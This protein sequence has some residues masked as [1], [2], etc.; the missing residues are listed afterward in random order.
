MSRHYDFASKML[1]TQEELHAR[2]R[3]TAERIAADYKDKNLT[4][5][6]NPLVLVCVLKGSFIFTADLARALCDAGVPV[7]VE[8][9][10]VAS[11][12]ADVMSS[13]QVRLLL[14]TR[15]SVEQRHVLLVEDIVD[16]AL[17]LQYLYAHYTARG[18]ASLRSV[19]LLDKPTGRRVSFSPDY[20][21][22]TVPN[23]FVVGYGLDYDESYREVRDVV[24]LDPKV[25]THR[26]QQK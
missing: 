7:R 18:P 16:S 12:G 5:L 23:A 2:I 10:C 24:V 20:V 25:Y 26:L 9:I 4:H 1:F 6:D 17:T 8:F 15:H 11:Y 21:I 14:D 22:A 3:S 19:V 13:G